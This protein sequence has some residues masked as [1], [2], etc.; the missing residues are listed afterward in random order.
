MRWEEKSSHVC[1]RMEMA[2]EE[3]E[4]I[5]AEGEVW[6]GRV[7]GRPC[8]RAGDLKYSEQDPCRV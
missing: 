4:V 3:R 1:T 7:M 8:L 6:R 5:G 2:L